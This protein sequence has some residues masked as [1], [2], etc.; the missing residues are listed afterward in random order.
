MFGVLKQVFLPQEWN[1]FDLMGKNSLDYLDLKAF[2]NYEVYKDVLKVALV[3]SSQYKS[4]VAY[5]T[6]TNR[7]AIEIG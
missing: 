7:L 4:N 5:R 1:S 6:S 3:L 2:L